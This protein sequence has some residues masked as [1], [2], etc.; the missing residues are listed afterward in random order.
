MENYSVECRH[1]PH[2]KDVYMLRPMLINP[3]VIMQYTHSV[4]I[5]LSP[6]SYLLAEHAQKFIIC[7]L[8]V[9]KNYFCVPHAFSVFFLCS[10]CHPCLCPLLLFLSDV[11]CPLSHVYVPCLS[12]YVPCLTFLFLVFCPSSYV[13]VPCL[14]SSVPC[15]AS[16]FQKLNIDQGHVRFDLRQK[17]CKTISCLCTF[18]KTQGYFPHNLHC[19]SCDYGS[20]TF[21]SKP[22]AKQCLMYIE[23]SKGRYLVLRPPSKVKSKD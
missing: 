6:H 9:R 18:Q 3:I 8:S 14:P 15:L 16:H 5:I 1:E 12:S 2:R 20:C 13:S 7:W 23:G 4:V 17:K 21:I 19:I 10:P 11:L 22:L